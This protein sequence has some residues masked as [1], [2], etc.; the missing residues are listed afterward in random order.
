LANEATRSLTLGN[1]IIVITSINEYR[2]K[3]LGSP[4]EGLRVVLIT[5]RKTSSP[6]V[7]KALARRF[8]DKFVF[9]EIRSGLSQELATD[10]MKDYKIDP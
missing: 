6:P 7:F 10:I 5:E 3:L 9:A 4:L 8:K 1:N 2:E